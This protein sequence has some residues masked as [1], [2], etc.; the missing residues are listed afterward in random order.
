M[1]GCMA[2]REAIEGCHQH[3]LQHHGYN[4]LRTQAL[5]GN[6]IVEGH[7]H[8]VW[9]TKG[10]NCHNHHTQLGKDCTEVMVEKD[11]VTLNYETCCWELSNSST[12]LVV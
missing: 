2:T 9:T 6:P 10:T 1:A 11:N 4:L 7:L 3:P 12:D 5:Y 8:V